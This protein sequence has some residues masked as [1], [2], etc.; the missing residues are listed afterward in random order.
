MKERFNEIE[1]RSI[2]IIQLNSRRKKYLKFNTSS[3]PVS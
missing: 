3:E 2:N 1:D